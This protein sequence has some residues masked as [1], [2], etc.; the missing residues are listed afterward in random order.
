MSLS[1]TQELRARVSTPPP[2]RAPTDR[3]EAPQSAFRRTFRPYGKDGPSYTLSLYDSGAPHPAGGAWLGYRLHRHDPKGPR[4]GA[5]LFAGADL[6][7]PRE[8]GSEDLTTAARDVLERLT[9]VPGDLTPDPTDQYSPEQLAFALREARALRE[10]V[11]G[12]L[13]WRPEVPFNPRADLG[14]LGLAHHTSR[15]KH[16][17]GREHRA[18]VGIVEASGPTR[19][20]AAEALF[21]AIGNHCAAE[22]E[23]WVGPHSGNVYALVPAG[24]LWAVHCI[25]QAGVVTKPA[26]FEASCL[27]SAQRSFEAAI[28]RLEAT[29]GPRRRPSARAPRAA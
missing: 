13:G 24:A 14:E 18:R 4:R 19:R 25:T 8:E 9:L 10:S 23:F 11:R 1:L 12:R 2:F 5:L 17:G 7:P 29:Y 21:R 15:A 6:P 22:P 28:Q 26:L 27:D 16:A 20:A 3:P